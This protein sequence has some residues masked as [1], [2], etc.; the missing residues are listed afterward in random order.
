MKE[1]KEQKSIEAALKLL[2]SDKVVDVDM[3]LCQDIGV[4][5]YIAKISDNEDAYTVHVIWHRY[6]HMLKLVFNGQTL[7]DGAVSADDGKRLMDEV[8]PL[9]KAFE[10]KRR[11][12][13]RIKKQQYEAET[14]NKIDAILNKF[15]RTL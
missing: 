9:Y 12:E 6:T 4:Y 14:I 1:T 11:E 7:F 3:P 2:K 13:E 10:E 15:Q 8:S 5:K